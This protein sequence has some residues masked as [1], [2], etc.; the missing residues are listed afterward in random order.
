MNIWGAIAG[1][2][3]GAG[4]GL[5][6]G[7]TMKDPKFPEYKP[8]PIAE[9]IEELDPYLK[10]DLAAR[11][12]LA[13]RF[14]TGEIPQE[15]REQ[16]EMLAAEKSWAGGWGTSPRAGNLTARDLGLMSLQIMQMGA[17][18]GDEITQY[19]TDLAIAEAAEEYKGFASRYNNKVAKWNANK[20]KTA[21]IWNDIL[22]FGMLGAL[23]G[24]EIETIKTS[25]NADGSLTKTTTKG[26]PN[27]SWGSPTTWFK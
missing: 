3:A 21:G 16:V 24:P 1:V 22:S 15:V 12:S 20:E 19:E 26:D 5:L 23:S 7:L 9:R 25:Y 17:K 2:G 11:R 14:M 13:N 6:R 10:E 4:V 18:M 27:F 8:T